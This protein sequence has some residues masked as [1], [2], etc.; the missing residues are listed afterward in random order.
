MRIRYIDTNTRSYPRTLQ[1]AFGPHTSREIQD[2]SKDYPPAWWC[3][4]VSC[5]LIGMVLVVV[6]A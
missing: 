1:E 6:T 3:W 2:D 4:V 5:A